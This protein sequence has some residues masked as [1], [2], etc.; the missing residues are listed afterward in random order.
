M[1][2]GDKA[3]YADS[4]TSY[5]NSDHRSGLTGNQAPPL[6]AV[7]PFSLPSYTADQKTQAGEE[8]PPDY[9]AASSTVVADDVPSYYWEP[10]TAL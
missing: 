4:Y 8:P 9:S 5:C 6:S 10:T 1:L 7:S 2:A 3:I